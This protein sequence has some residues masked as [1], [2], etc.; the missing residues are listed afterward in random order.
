MSLRSWLARVGR[1]GGGSDLG[2]FERD[3]LS[4][5][6][7][8]H[9][10]ALRMTRSEADAEDLVQDTVLRAL[11]FRDRY[12]PGTNLKAWLLRMLTNLFINR[13]RSA[14]R[15]RPARD[16]AEAFEVAEPGD[17]E[18]SLRALSRALE[19][20][21]RPLIAAEIQAALERLSEEHRLVILLSD[22]EELSYREIA[23]VL[24]CPIG[25]VMSRLHRARHAV[26]A[27]LVEQAAALG[28]SV[29]REPSSAQS[30]AA[31]KPVSLDA[32]RRRRERSR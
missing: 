13:Y 22:V 14:L 26:R 24:G 29:A 32:W 2:P 17:P 23:D 28:L 4:H 1:F 6:D 16:E 31:S 27:H 21:E 11:R 20:A 19:E 15:E 12:E 5:L 7:V 25:T 18:G 30:A 10:V 9:R 3:V 8:L